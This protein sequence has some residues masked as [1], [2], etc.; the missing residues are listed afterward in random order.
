M[1]SENQ[2]ICCYYTCKSRFS[3]SCGYRS[4]QRWLRERIHHCPM[5]YSS[6]VR[7]AECFDRVSGSRAGARSGG[8]DVYRHCSNPAERNASLVSDR[9]YLLQKP[10][11]YFALGSVS[12]TV[13][14]CGP[15]PVP[16]ATKEVGRFRWA[17]ICFFV[18]PVFYFRPVQK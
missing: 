14:R 1:S 3:S 16:I 12:V 7:R 5:S 17:I 13:P 10:S 18:A 9:S 6:F 2:E 11:Q 15:L 4:A 8:R